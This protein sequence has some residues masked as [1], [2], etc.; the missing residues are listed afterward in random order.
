MRYRTWDPAGRGFAALADRV[1]NA[2]ADGV[3]LAGLSG[4]NLGKLARALRTRLGSGL[5]LIGPDPAGPPEFVY[6]QSDRI[7]KGMYMSE[8]GEAHVSARGRQFVRDVKATRPGVVR[9]EV[10][11]VAAATEVL[12]E[13]IARSDG[14]RA[15]VARELFAIR[16]KDGFLGPLHFDRN[17]DPVGPPVTI[18]RIGSGGRGVEDR[19]IA[20]PPPG[21]SRTRGGAI[22]G[23]A[24]LIPRNARRLRWPRPPLRSRRALRRSASS[25]AIW[26]INPQSEANMR[27]RL[28]VASGRAESL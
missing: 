1:R 6:D 17:G 3:F 18:F 8:V 27:G 10:P 12:L 13:A 19:V 7:A 24:Q 20:A 14:T 5:T 22:S 26:E 16:Q 15:S 2:H 21:R 25:C 23:H 4:S 9:G 28:F 11:Y